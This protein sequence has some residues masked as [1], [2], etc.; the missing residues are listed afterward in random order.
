MA[1]VWHDKTETVKFLLGQEANVN[2]T[3]TKSCP[4]YTALQAAVKRNSPTMVGILLEHG[5]DV[6]LARRLSSSA[7]C[8]AIREGSIDITKLLVEAKADVGSSRGMPERLAI[9]KN[10]RDIL[11]ILVDHGV[12]PGRPG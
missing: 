8:A 7:L 3:S 11:E 4:Y 12:V 5:A 6:N 10:R 1:A 9:Q 2:A